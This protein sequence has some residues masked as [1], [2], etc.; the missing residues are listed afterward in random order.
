MTQEAVDHPLGHPLDA[1]ALEEDPHRTI[2]EIS[3][4]MCAFC[5]RYCSTPLEILWEVLNAGVWVPYTLS[6]ENNLQ[7]SSICNFLLNWWEKWVPY[8]KTAKAEH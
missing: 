8:D 2:E 4:K 5:G 3:E 1:N 6:I 7:R